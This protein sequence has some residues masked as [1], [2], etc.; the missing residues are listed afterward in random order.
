MVATLC[1]KSAALVKTSFL[2]I[3]HQTQISALIFNLASMSVARR[4]LFRILLRNPTLMDPVL[5]TPFRAMTT[6]RLLLRQIA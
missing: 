2:S 3:I 5:H 4:E 6:V 1:R